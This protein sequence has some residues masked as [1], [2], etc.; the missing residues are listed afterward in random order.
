MKKAIALLLVMLVGIGVI[1]GCGGSGTKLSGK[2]Y[3]V[4]DEETKQLYEE[5]D[6][7]LPEMYL[8]F[9][10]GGK[11][12]FISTFD[13]ETETEDG[14]FKITDKTVDIT[15]DGDTVTGTIDDKKITVDFGD[16]EGPTVFE[17]K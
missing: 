9:L 17:K 3:M 6:M 4:V 1:A 12:K 2:Y 5:Y 16:D 10:S 8:E 11:L 13:G 14:T 7:A 15:I